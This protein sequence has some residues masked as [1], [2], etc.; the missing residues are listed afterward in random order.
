MRTRHALVLMVATLHGSFCIAAAADALV[1]GPQRGSRLPDT[2]Q[3]VPLNVTNAE[4]PSYAG[5]KN[6]YVEQFGGNPVALVFAREITDPLVNLMKKLD[7]EVSKNKAARL[8]GVFIILSDDN[9][10]E[11][12][13]REL[14]KREAINSVSLAIMSEGPKYYKLSEEADVTVV[15]YRHRKVAANHSFRK[16]ELNDKAVGKVLADTSKLLPMSDEG[17]R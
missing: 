2:F 13:L 10:T 14:G 11:R 9:K 8:R 15:L 12:M 4:L 6:D 7:A 3:P 1:S 17:T 5:K 16:G